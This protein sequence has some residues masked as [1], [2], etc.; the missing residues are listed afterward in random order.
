MNRIALPL[1]LLAGLTLA[2][3]AAAPRAQNPTPWPLGR[4]V[5]STIANDGDAWLP[6]LAC[7]PTVLD[8]Q[9]NL[10]APISCTV[11]QF[12]MAPGETWTTWWDQRDMLGQQV[13]PG[14]YFVDGQPFELGATPLGVAP[15]GMPHPGH[16]RRFALSAPT[17]S[18]RPYVVAASLSATHGTALGCG[19]TFP[20]DDD[21]LL[22]LSLSTPRLFPDFL[23]VLD[24]FGNS[25]SPAIALPDLPALLGLQFFVAAATLDAQGPCGL[26][27]VG[28]A[29]PVVVQ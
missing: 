26:G 23:G 4:P 8:A 24:A 15:L 7:T 3:L 16:T 10:V 5:P 9:G 28:D 12:A 22:A 20:L 19:R 17:Q 2:A 13:L 6:Y 11:T 14:I 18:H 25:T 1:P 29:V 21:S 27:V